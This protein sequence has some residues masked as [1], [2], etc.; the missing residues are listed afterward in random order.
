M[1]LACFVAA[2]VVAECAGQPADDSAARVARC[3]AAKA[4]LGTLALPAAVRTPAV[5]CAD[6]S[7]SCTAGETGRELAGLA[8]AAAPFLDAQGNAELDRLAAALNG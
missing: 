7:A 8:M 1:A 5:R 4:W 2:R 3:A 6:A